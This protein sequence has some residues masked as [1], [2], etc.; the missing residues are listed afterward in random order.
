MLDNN[1]VEKIKKFVA[2]RAMNEAVRKV[3]TDSFLKTRGVTEV[4]FLAAQR[5]AID[6][7]ED[8]YKELNK[9]SRTEKQG[10]KD[11]EQIGL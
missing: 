11:I 7:L 5:I 1:Q 3:L 2:D 6:L 9:I 8:G 4:N 10:K